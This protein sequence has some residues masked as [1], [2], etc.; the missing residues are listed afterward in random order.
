MKSMAADPHGE[1]PGEEPENRSKNKNK[2]KQLSVLRFLVDFAGQR[3][4]EKEKTG[5]IHPSPA[6]S[7]RRV[8]STR[9]HCSGEVLEDGPSNFLFLGFIL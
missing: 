2:E 1:D 6:L 5:Q 4:E 3:R 9:H 8:R 7:R